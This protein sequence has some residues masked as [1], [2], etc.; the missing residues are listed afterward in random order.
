[1]NTSSLALDKIY[2]LAYNVLKK[3]GCDHLNAEAVATIV[4][5]AERDGSIS[6]GLFRI[7]GYIAALNS[8]KVKGNSKPNHHFK[9]PNVEH[10]DVAANFIA[11]TDIKGKEF[12]LLDIDHKRFLVYDLDGKYVGASSLPKDLK[13]RSKNHFNGLGYTNNGYY[14]VYID[15]EGEHGTYHAYKVIN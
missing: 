3:H 11:F 12:I 10:H 7:P 9:T 15:S 5:H 14:F 1:M 2:D 4:M 6:H 13:L 8:K